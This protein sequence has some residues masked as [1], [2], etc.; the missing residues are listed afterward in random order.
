MIRLLYIWLIRLHPAHFRQ[1]FGDEMLWI[2][3]Q[4]AGIR[5]GVSLLA[6]AFLSLLRQWT[7]RPGTPAVSS[8]GPKPDGV[9]VFYTI[10]TSLPR[11]VLMNGGVWTV[12][13][14]AALSF[15]IGRGGSP[16][17]SWIDIGRYS[18]PADR[19][20]HQDRWAKPLSMFGSPVFS[21]RQPNKPD[22]SGQWKL[23]INKSDFG[24]MPAPSSALMKIEH[25][26]PGLKITRTI[27]TDDGKR[28][29]ETV[30]STDGKDITVKLPG[31]NPGKST[32]KW[33]G[34]ALVIESMTSLNGEEFRVRW[35]WTLSKD[36]KTLTTV[37]TF[38]RGEAAQTEVYEIKLNL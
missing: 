25:K 23:N 37:R 3:D 18:N 10:D 20:D 26:E 24:Q 35:K 12:A 32:A 9:P 2:F 8:T 14:F 30:Y 21:Q 38:S 6:D 29:T 16:G 15:V 31:S 27:G 34:S 19:G 5:T 11:G 33:D 22:F 4:A 13:I 7:F 17:I 36:G 1:Q 28:T